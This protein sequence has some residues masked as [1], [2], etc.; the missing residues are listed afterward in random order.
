MAPRYRLTHKFSTIVKP[1]AEVQKSKVPKSKPKGLWL[2]IIIII[3]LATHP[4]TW[5]PAHST[6]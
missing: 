5:P 6:P 2:I 3:T 4:T 1:K